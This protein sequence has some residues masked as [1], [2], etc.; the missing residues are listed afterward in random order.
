MKSIWWKVDILSNS[1][2]NP[3]SKLHTI[4]SIIQRE[5][6]SGKD[7]FKASCERK[8]SEAML[9]AMEARINKLKQ[10]QNKE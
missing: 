4:H 10:V 6:H 2:E 9:K 3:N 5:D 7:M 1:V 8:E